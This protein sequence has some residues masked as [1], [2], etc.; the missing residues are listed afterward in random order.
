[1][2]NK[3][4]K[5]LRKEI[6]YDVTAKRKYTQHEVTV[7]RNI[8]SF[9]PELKRMELVLRPVSAFIT[10]CTDSGRA[11]YK[12]LKRKWNNP[13][14]EMELNQL[15]SKEELMELQ[16]EIM[17]DTE[18]VEDVNKNQKKVQEEFNKL[19]EAVASES[20]ED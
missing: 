10:E 3:V 1:M 17:R 6:D 12:Y 7:M 18:V 5:A 15:P 19:T 13:D 8:Y 14:L 20:K 2:R 16:R 11:I 4:A 9:N